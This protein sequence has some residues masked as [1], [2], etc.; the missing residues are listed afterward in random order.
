[1]S[2]KNEL[3][4]LFKYL[5]EI[6]DSN[7]LW[8]VLDS[9]T[10]LGAIRNNK[11]IEWDDDIDLLISIDAYNFLKKNYPN[12]FLDDGTNGYPFIFAK[13][14]PSVDK[15]LESNIF[16]DLFIAIPTTEKKAKKYFSVKNKI[17]FTSQLLWK[18]SKWNVIDFKT[19]LLKWV[20]SP[21]QLFCKRINFTEVVDKFYSPENYNCVLMLNSP[22][23]SMKKEIYPRETMDR[24]KIIFEDI[25]TWVPVPY[26]DILERKYGKD[27]MIPKR[28]KNSFIHV[29]SINIQ[30]SD[31]SKKT[32]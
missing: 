29:D 13:F 6:L 3:L 25:T 1:M 31:V 27:Y 32:S 28:D 11:M 30:R 10:L 24:K 20:I 18:K 17:R 23:S 15:Y 14:V 16:I 19:K 8:Y 26:K 9:G 5:I 4:H 12:N 22:I 21:I 7:N 2:N